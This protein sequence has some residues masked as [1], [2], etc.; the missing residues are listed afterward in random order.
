MLVI[1]ILVASSEAA[2]SGLT[3]AEIAAFQPIQAAR[4]EQN[5]GLLGSVGITGE[6]LKMF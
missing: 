4:V 1:L 5:T 3:S 6:K 2:S